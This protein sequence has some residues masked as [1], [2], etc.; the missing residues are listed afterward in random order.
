MF[1][2]IAKHLP[3]VS[4]S[5]FLFVMISQEFFVATYF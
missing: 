2:L 3:I 1:K 5:V 4:V